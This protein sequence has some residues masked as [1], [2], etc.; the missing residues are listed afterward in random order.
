M[1]RSTFMARDM[2]NNVL[3]FTEISKTMLLLILLFCILLNQSTGISPDGEALL[4]FKMAIVSSDGILLQ[5]RPED[6]DPCSWKGV[7]CDAKTKRVI[8]LSL[9][10][11]KLSGFISPDIG[12]LNNLQVLALHNNNLYGAIP[13]QLANCAQLRG[14]YLQANYLSGLLPSELGDLAELEILD[15]SSN[16]LSGSIPS[17]LEK[18]NKL[19]TLN[20]SSN[21]FMGSIPSEG[22]LSKFATSSFTG[23]RGLC[24]VQISV[25]CKDDNGTASDSQQFGSENQSSKRS[26]RESA[27]LFVSASATVGAL[28]L[29]ALMCF[30]GCFLYK[31]FGKSEGKGLSVDVSGGASIV[32]FHGDLPYSSK[33]IIKKLESLDDEHLISSGG[34]GT[35][36]RLDMDDGNVFA[37]K[38]IMKTNDGLDRF[39]ERELEILGSIKHRYLVNLRGYCNSPSS[40]LLI[41]DFLPGGSLDEVLHE[42]SEHLEW[43]ARVNI[44][45]GAAKGLSYLH[46][47]C[48]PR[49]I[50]R[51]IKSSNI[52]LDGNLEA[53]VSD[54]GLAKLLEDEE[55][56]IT[57]IV[58]GTFGY[59]A[60][61][62]MQSGRATE[63]TDV[64][65]FGVLVLE[66]LSSR[67][68]TDAT[69]I[70]KG[71]NIVGWLNFLVVEN[72]QREIVDP[73]CE[74]VQ[75]ESLDA[76]LSL[77]IQCVSSN[78]E[79][80]PTMHRVVQILESEVMTPCPSDFYDSN[81]E[82]SMECYE[83]E[84][85][86]FTFCER[87]MPF[88]ENCT[89]NCFRCF[90]WMAVN[91]FLKDGLGVAPS[92]LQ[93]LQNSANIPM[94][95]KPLYG[96]V[97]DAVYIRGE[98]RLPY[99]VAG[100]LLQAA[101]WLSIAFIP[102]SYLSIII[103]SL[104][105]L[106]SNL[107]ASIV[108]VANDALVAE[109][110]GKPT[111]KNDDSSPSAKPG[112]PSSSS[113]GELQSFA[114]MMASLG[115][116]LGNLLGGVAMNLFTPR[117]MFLFF[118]LL[119]IIQFLLTITLRERSLNLPKTSP[120][121][122]IGHKL[123]ELSVA[124]KRPQLSRAIAWFAAS[125]A[126]IPVLL[127]TMF[128]YQTQHLKLSSSVIGLSK[129]FGQAALL[130]WSA[131][132]N[133]WLNWVPPR[134]LI[135]AVQATIAVFM[136][137]DALF[138][139]E[140]Y[141]QLGVPDSVYV[142]GFSGL[143]EVLFQFKVLPFIVVVAQL[144]P[145][146]CE[147]SLMA[148]LMSTVA[149][150]TIV[151]GYLGVALAAITGVSAEDFSALPLAILIQ[152]SCTLVP[153]Y[154]NSWIPD[155]VA[156]PDQK[157]KN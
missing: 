89:A 1:I 20:L 36:Y 98:H 85:Y 18:L 101:S 15:V 73:D 3:C 64:Y 144:C 43:D 114:W 79:D 68:P 117:I 127:G 86:K 34:F 112:T 74:G 137:S 24:G 149:L 133:R 66:I 152:A 139:K 80:R 96:V 52:L 128:F 154:W 150:A 40:K 46:H 135:S 11:H 126:V 130:A 76:L 106:L 29:V 83:I 39:F 71:L 134:K 44:I 55:S 131:A 10:H 105:L 70:E 97:S 82:R 21:F 58:A 93:L 8:Y 92:T 138:V 132:Y 54:F 115:G 42:R 16:T 22:A 118:G 155:Y 107:G 33:D 120:S 78:P 87:K 90:P 145:P 88:E 17:T 51:D 19:S 84:V 124:L 148:F 38:R 4:S 5:W 37:L 136:V 30:W 2:Y 75:L 62:Y 146:G 156:E 104:F 111:T 147:G 116:I 77:A 141:K 61:E 47:D 81:S 12:R 56:H 123:S 143:L 99:I 69:F 122:G 31:K 140:M 27:K 6:P 48:S 102:S 28:L 151:S 35:V 113:S 13:S 53:R 14:L 103:I 67:R 153:I 41:Y 26:P 50:H 60:P 95:G 9:P 7:E 59:L 72:R 25:K 63:K 125:Y 129:V 100:V 121:T 49:I 23:N 32:M 142:V 45:I 157:K 109:S 91:Y 65:S 108:E 110:R 119:L 94:V 57:T